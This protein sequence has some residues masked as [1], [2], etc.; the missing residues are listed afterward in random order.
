MCLNSVDRVWHERSE[1]HTAGVFVLPFLCVFSRQMFIWE[2]LISE[3][4]FLH[5]KFSFGY[6]IFSCRALKIELL[7]ASNKNRLRS[8][9]ECQLDAFGDAGVDRFKI[10]YCV[11]RTHQNC[12]AF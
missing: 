10:V 9:I 8:V 7:I 1:Q 11:K 5:K 12:Q 2:L 4:S 3:I 6:Q